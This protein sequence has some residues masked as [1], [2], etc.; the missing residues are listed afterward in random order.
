MSW[1]KLR[2]VQYVFTDTAFYIT[3]IF[4]RFCSMFHILPLKG[5]EVVDPKYVLFID[6][7]IVMPHFR[8]RTTYDEILSSSKIS[9]VLLHTRTHTHMHASKY[10]RIHKHIHTLLK[11]RG[12]YMWHLFQY[13]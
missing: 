7:I 4:Y 10:P 13:L 1:E 12:N 5:S 2:E 11:L 6:I 3:L 8:F 9:R